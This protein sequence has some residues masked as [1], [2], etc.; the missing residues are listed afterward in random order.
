MVHN[1]MKVIEAIG[2]ALALSAGFLALSAT[3]LV[4]AAGQPSNGSQPLQTGG[5]V[6]GWCNY[7]NDQDEDDWCWSTTSTSTAP[8]ATTSTAITA[9][10]P[11]TGSGYAAPAGAVP[12]GTIVGQLDPYQD[13]H[14]TGNNYGNGNNFGYGNFFG[15]MGYNNRYDGRHYIVKGGKYKIMGRYKIFTRNGKPVIVNGN[16][17]FIGKKWWWLMP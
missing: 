12:Y 11:M 9:T 4:F 17:Y 6:P 1:K 15:G 16:R 8:T 10:A 14:G 2:L 3:N 7:D 5:R 13:I